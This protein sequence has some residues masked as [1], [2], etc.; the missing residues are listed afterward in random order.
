[1]LGAPVQGQEAAAGPRPLITQTVDESELTTLRGNTH[2]L[3]RPEN[4][5]GT[6]PASLPMARMLLVLKRG[7]DQEAALRKLLDDQQDKA[8]PNY[9]QW[10][11]PEQYG[12]QFGP[13]DND[14]QTITAW[15]QSHG[16]EVGS[17]KGRT[18]LEFSGTAGQVQEAFHTT[19]HK[20]IVKGEQHWA[21]ASDP[22]IPT[23]L[24]PAVAGIDSLHNFPRKAMNRFVGTYS[25]KTKSLTTPEPNY[26]LG[27]GYTIACG[28]GQTCYAVSPYDFATIYDVLP[29][30]NASPAINGTGETIAIVGRTNINPNDPTT[31]W[32][33]FGLTVPANKLN[34]ILNG[35]DPGINNDEGEA[36][37]DIQWSGAV[38]PQATIDFV[39]SQTTE[40][41]DGVDLSAVYI[42]ENNLAPVMSESYGEC[43]LGLGTGGNQFYYTLWEQAAAQGISVFVSTGDN[44]SAG[45]DGEGAPAQYG[46]NVNGIASTP[47]NAAIGGTDFNQY[48]NQASY[49]NPT[50]GSNEE[51]AKGYIAEVAWNNSCTNPWALTAGLGSTAEQV[52]NNPNLN[53]F[54]LN[55]SGGSGG[56]SNCVLNTQGVPGSCTGKYPKPSWQMGTNVPNDSSRDLPDVS[57]FAS[58]GVLTLSFYVVCQSDQ[59]GGCSLNAFA[60]YGGTS[61]ASPAFAG[62]MSLANQKMGMPQGVPGFALYQLAAKQANAFHDVPS[63]STIAMPCFSGTPNCTT[64]TNGD[65]YGVLSGYSTGTGYDLATGLGSVDAANLVNNWSKA[66]F[67]AT[68]ATLKLNNGSA[69]NVTH[70]TAVPVTIDVS[71]TAATGVAS[72]LVSNAS[73]TTIGQGIDGFSLTSGAT[74]S[75]AATSLLPGGTNYVIAHYG[76]DGTY[77]GSYSAPVSVT[78]G[79]E[80]STPIIGGLILS[81]TTIPVKTVAFDAQYF[82]RADVGNSQG[83]LCSPPPFGEIACPT[84]GVIFTVDG[85]QL[86]F[87]TFP[88]NSEGYTETTVSGTGL[89]TGGTHTLAAQYS[90]DSNY[91]AS[92]GSVAITVTR[93]ATETTQVTAQG[94]ITQTVTLTANIED[95][96]AYYGLATTPTGTVTFYSNGTAIPGTP[97]LSTGSNGSTLYTT[98]TLTTTFPAAGTYTLTA[99]YG[100]DQNYQPSASAASQVTLQYPSPDVY[101]NPGSQNVLPGTPVTV[102]VLVDTHNKKQPPTGTV[103][104]GGGNVGTLGGPTA[105]AQT[106]DSSGNY[107]CQATFTFTPPPPSVS[108]VDSFWAQYSGDANYPASQDGLYWI[109]II[110]FSLSPNS[111]QVTVTQGSSQTVAINVSPQNGFNAAVTNFSCSGLPA[112]TTC[113]F[114]PATVTGGS[115]STTLTITTTPLGQKKQMRR[116][117]NESHRIG[118]MAIAILPLLGICLIGLPSWR[119]RGVLPL[120]V[121]VAL[122][123][124]LPSCGGGSSTPPPPPPNPVPS[125]TSLSPTQQAAGSTLQAVTIAGSGFISGSTVTYNNVA[126]TATYTSA[127][128]LGI[129]LTSADLAN[130]GSFPVVVTNPTPGGGSSSAV[131]FNVVT[132]TPVGSFNVTVTASSGSLTQTTN[133]TLTVQ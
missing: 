132:G 97:V 103:T 108:T 124:A 22:S 35:P 17:T 65:S 57:L 93:A 56:P 40:T 49:W 18:V 119:R 24:T 11:T 59:T 128:Q 9:H 36:D 76:G 25:E 13:T 58:N 5:L 100:G 121:I 52:C 117:S 55:S 3:A 27:P 92:T 126:H 48:N 33:L 122:F 95:P 77:G 115:G 47:F 70:G 113:G 112:E 41:T 91:N 111:P 87:N 102:T 61:V 54:F 63:G 105:C 66:T 123:L 8:S 104:L 43:E 23:A 7:N 78:V 83:N 60:G 130:T 39:T 106:T 14:L 107:A 67:T 72:L 29:L 30:W 6:A 99:S 20:Y 31:F 50:N 26:S 19:I 82:E 80:N 68:T 74:A 34:I 109:T 96:T 129:S 101:A 45:C 38:A 16:F 131:N 51:S 89:I 85:S 127:S 15:L 110:A 94:A 44:G 79:K 1:M 53:P 62:I 118:W 133:F 21:N 90:G 98:A 64:Q 84:G 120:L 4:D 46:L 73:G 86:N 12:L 28:G 81:G 116:A 2:P 69:V 75:G 71:P 114:S 37:I 125:I 32:S 42:V 10:L 88:L